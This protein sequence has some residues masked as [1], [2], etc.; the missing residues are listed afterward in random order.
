[1]GYFG[2][3][4]SGGDVSNGDKIIKSVFLTKTLYKQ[5]VTI[6]TIYKKFLKL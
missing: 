4:S 3:K 2:S 6:K 1:M 5:A